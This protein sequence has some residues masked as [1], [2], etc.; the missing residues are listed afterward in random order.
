VGQQPLAATEYPLESFSNSS[1][2]VDTRSYQEDSEGTEGV[3]TD[4][5]TCSNSSFSGDCSIGG[6]VGKA[7]HVFEYSALFGHFLEDNY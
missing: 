3:D 1:S 5:T 7:G 2:N 6:D 4:R